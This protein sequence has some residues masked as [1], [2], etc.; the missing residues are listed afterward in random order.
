M[1]LQ[2]IAKWSLHAIL[3]VSVDKIAKM[4][5]KWQL[6]LLISIQTI[7]VTNQNINVWPIAF[8]LLRGFENHSHPARLKSNQLNLIF[9]F[10]IRFI[11]GRW[12]PRKCRSGTWCWTFIHYFIFLIGSALSMDPN[13]RYIR[14]HCPRDVSRGALGYF[15]ELFSKFFAW[16]M[17]FFNSWF[18]KWFGYAFSCVFLR[19]SH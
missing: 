8:I 9:F 17:L 3:G 13:R 1:T 10:R 12:W 19:S 4:G 11:Y 15:S 5:A 7:T 18:S 16:K 6:F 2:P 14:V